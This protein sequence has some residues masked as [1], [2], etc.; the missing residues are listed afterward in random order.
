MMKELKGRV[1]VITG[2]AGGIGRAMGERF[3]HEGMK[4]VLADL[5]EQ[6]LQGTVNDLRGQ[7]AEVIGVPTDVSKL[8]S[9]EALRD[10]TLAQFGKV[11]VV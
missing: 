3:A 6:N 5:N 2:G 1:A 4:L 9:V 11:H 10:A 8:E 7:G